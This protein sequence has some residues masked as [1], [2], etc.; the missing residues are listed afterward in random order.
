M[1]RIAV[2]IIGLLF[3][4]VAIFNACRNICAY[5]EARNSKGSMKL[6]IR[7]ARWTWRV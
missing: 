6:R 7:Q 5:L 2:L 1:P 4:A 3:V